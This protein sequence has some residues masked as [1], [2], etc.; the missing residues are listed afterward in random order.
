M[1]RKTGKA[2]YRSWRLKMVCVIISRD[3]GIGI[4]HQRFLQFRFSRGD[5]LRTVC[6]L[7]KFLVNARGSKV[8]NGSPPR[9]I[10]E[11]WLSLRLGWLSFDLLGDLRPPAVARMD[12]NGDANRWYRRGHGRRYRSPLS[13]GSDG[14]EVNDKQ[15][16][17]MQLNIS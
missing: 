5:I 2:G 3:L 14:V 15:R 4:N 1:I 7:R 11:G 6:F 8:L 9:R 13:M 17:E 12:E 16:K 10:W